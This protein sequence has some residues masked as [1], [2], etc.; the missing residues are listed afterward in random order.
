M[1]SAS[2]AMVQCE[3]K[4]VHQNKYA[5][6]RQKYFVVWPGAVKNRRVCCLYDLCL[7][8]SWNF[9][10]YCIISNYGKRNGINEVTVAGSDGLSCIW[11]LTIAY[12]YKRNAGYI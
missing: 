11:D 2:F 7:F 12:E 6:R 3:S 5:Y 9:S 1:T 8:N 4:K 10:R